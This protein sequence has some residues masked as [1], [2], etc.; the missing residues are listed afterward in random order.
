MPPASEEEDAQL[1]ASLKAGFWSQDAIIV[2]DNLILDGCRRW[3][4][5]KRLKI[6]PVIKHWDKEMGTPE[7]FILA[8][9]YAR[10]N[11]TQA[12]KRELLDAY[13]RLRPQDSNR[14]IAAA[15]HVDH[16]TVDAHRETLEGRGEIPHVE[17]L[18]DT[19]GRKQPA[20]K[21]KPEEESPPPPPEQMPTPP[22]PANAAQAL[23]LERLTRAF[24]AHK[25]WRDLGQ[26]AKMLAAKISTFAKQ[27][28]CAFVGV[29]EICG[30]LD[31][32]FTHVWRS[33]PYAVCPFCQGQPE[34]VAKCRTCHGH[35]WL[36]HDVFERQLPEYKIKPTTLKENA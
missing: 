3:E 18:T 13:L 24:A 8:R 20:K 36:P 7:E 1:E 34:T 27:Q 6:S 2:H 32:V 26:E 9:A 5:C 12:G 19:A 4:A 22:T 31:G 28:P 17:K 25:S 33:R 15:T 21:R 30:Q 10:R 16:K 23:K 35:G 14:K 29:Q 11:L